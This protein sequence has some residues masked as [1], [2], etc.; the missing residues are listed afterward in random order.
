LLTV[1]RMFVWTIHPVACVSESAHDFRMQIYALVCILAFREEFASLSWMQILALCR[2]FVAVREMSTSLLL[3][4]GR[5]WI[6]TLSFYKWESLFLT[7]TLVI[8]YWRGFCLFN[9]KICRVYYWAE[10]L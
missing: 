5:S 6:N 1:L 9:A 2:R 7:L 8:N 4:L 10:S 3:F